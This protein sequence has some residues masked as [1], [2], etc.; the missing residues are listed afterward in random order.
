MNYN[1]KKKT[2]VSPEIKSE[3]VDKTES[4]TFNAGFENGIYT[5]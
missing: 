4:G 1:E 5:T 3:A 2:W